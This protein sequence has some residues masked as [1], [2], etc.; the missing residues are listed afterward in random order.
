MKARLFTAMAAFALTAAVL[1]VIGLLAAWLFAPAAP[2]PRLITDTFEFTLAP[3]WTCDLEEGD[4]VCT[5]GKPPHEA[6]AIITLKRRGPDDN[7]AAYEEHLRAPKPG[8]A[9]TLSTVESVGHVALAG[10]DWVEAVHLGSEVPNYITIYRATVTSQVGVLAT[11]SFH[12]DYE[13]AVRQDM[14]AMMRTL[15]IHQRPP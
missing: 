15:V 1:G 12:R 13:K 6:I 7:L 14:N 11:F 4:H 8:N 9:G 3:G 2:Q 5:K 10:H